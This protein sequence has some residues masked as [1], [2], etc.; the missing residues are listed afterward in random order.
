L[1]T[2]ADL[3]LCRSHRLLRDVP[4][5]A[6][7]ALLARCQI[8]QLGAGGILLTPGEENHTLFFLLQGRLRVRLHAGDPGQS[9]IIQP[10]EIIGEMSIIEQRAVAARVEVDVRST[11]LAMPDGV[12]WS[13]YC[14]L[15]QVIPLL[16]ESL[17]AR[18]RKT[19]AV[20]QEELERK[21]RYELLQRE[22]ESAGKIP[23]NILPADTPLFENPAVDV[24]AFIKPARVVGGDFYD[25]VT[26]SRRRVAVAIGDVSGKGMP[27][28]LFM[29]RALTL[30]RM[31]LL[32]ERNPA[33]ILP[34]V[35]RQL[36]AAN[37]EFMFVTLAV[38]LIDTETGQATFLHAGRL[39]R[40]R[41]MGSMPTTSTCSMK[42]RLRPMARRS[43]RRASR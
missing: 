22:V 18:M 15:P 8:V 21:V 42:P 32:R 26:I 19:N 36:C 34:A 1:S 29:V 16:M 28:A 4:E 37:D 11:L 25:A 13:E 27:A 12:F 43:K 10:G 24:H 17:I 20:L 9:F 41:C 39:P 31:V 38:I 7:T 14:P 30:L 40:S 5:S 33:R 2:A 6:L 35:N 23:A 3:A